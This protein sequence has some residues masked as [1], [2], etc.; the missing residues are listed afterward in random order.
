[1]FTTIA[2]LNGHSYAIYRNSVNTTI[3]AEDISENIT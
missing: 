1:M 2:K 3:I